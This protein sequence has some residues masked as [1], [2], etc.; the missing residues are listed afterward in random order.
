MAACVSHY[1][2]TTKEILR[3]KHVF[4][5]LLHY[6][7]QQPWKNLRGYFHPQHT[8][9]HLCMYLN[10]PFGMIC[11][12]GVLRTFMVCGVTCCCHGNCVPFWREEVVGTR[13]WSK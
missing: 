13:V 6:T 9:P 3:T 1:C 12:G 8:F 7:T 10:G 5:M 2:A 11:L 4:S